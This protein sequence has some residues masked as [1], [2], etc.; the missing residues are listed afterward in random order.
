MLA[1]PDQSAAAAP[2]PRAHVSFRKHFLLPLVALVGTLA[3]I[4]GSSLYW[5]TAQQDEMQLAAECEL[6]QSALNSRQASLRRNLGDYAVWNEAYKRLALDFDR[7][8]AI[9]NIAP[10]LSKV[11]HY[12]YA[13]VVDGQGQTLIGS[14]GNSQVTVPA[15][16]VLG[17]PFTL[18]LRQL[19]A[20]VAGSDRRVSGL[21][22]ADGRP[23]LFGAAAIVPSDDV[24]RRPVADRYLVVA[25]VLDAPTLAEVGEEFGIEALHHD[26]QEVERAQMD[27]T[28]ASGRRLGVLGWEADEPGTELRGKLL[29][30]LLLMLV[31]MTGVAGTV[32]RH[33]RKALVDITAERDRAERERA[34]AEAALEDLA[35]ARRKIVEDSAE[36]RSTLQ[37]TVKAV[38]HKHD[39]L[40][41]KTLEQRRGELVE[42]AQTYQRVLGLVYDTLNEAAEAL[43]DVAR[44]PCGEASGNQLLLSA[45]DLQEQ[46]RYLEEESRRFLAR[47]QAA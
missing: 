33:G 27:V 38:E 12:D 28:D 9:E 15:E 31:L 36:F 19:R 29:P 7:E 40:L 13:F 25:R 17:R 45:G 34:T 42:L 30:W 8:W 3:I 41:E 44:V 21:T 6:I 5:F 1:I 46:A 2:P 16:A 32:L 23:T 18:A 11:Q 14:R 22:K 24:L 39:K 47:L 37:R 43:S 4:L 20:G 10:Y 35:S 26:E